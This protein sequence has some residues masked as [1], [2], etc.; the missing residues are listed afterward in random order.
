[1]DGGRGVTPVQVSQI[2][3]P[4]GVRA[5]S[6]LPVIDY[7]DSFTV[8][9]T[10]GAGER[11]PE[12]WARAVL[13]GAPPRVRIKLVAGWTFLGLRLGIRPPA[14]RILGW[15]IRRSTP[16][17]LLLGAGS[18]LGLPAE[19]LFRREP[20]GVLFATF[21]RQ[22]SRL[23]RTVWPRVIPGHQRVVASLLAHGAQRLQDG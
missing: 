17:V 11:T 18:R 21:V 7:A 15:R 13:A 22:R 16:D 20:D 6:T 2:D 1:M 10:G 14:M 19:L 8:T 5:L 3:P 23:A 4:P 9:V 12:Q